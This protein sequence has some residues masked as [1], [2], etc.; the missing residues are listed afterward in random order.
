[1]NAIK[2]LWASITRKSDELGEYPIQQATYLDRVSDV[3][4]LFPYGMHANL[5]VDQLGLLIDQQGRVFIGTSAVGRI[6]VEEGEVVFYHPKTNSKIHFKNNGDIDLDT[7][8]AQE[9]GNFNIN[10]KNVNIITSE[11]TVV[12][13]TGDV[14]ITTG[15]NATIAATGNI[16]VSAEGTVLIASGSTLDTDSVGAT[17]IKAPSVTVDSPS[18]TL[19]SGGSAIAR[20]GDN[21]QVT[22]P[23]GSSAGTYTG[24]ITGGGVNTSA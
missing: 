18:V 16:D 17:T 14:D 21:I 4:V 9:P 6:T 15:G 2:K 23:G 8:A 19:G 3:F 20:T 11:K 13:A 7:T 24:T 12:T 1:M 22:I 5:P 10:V